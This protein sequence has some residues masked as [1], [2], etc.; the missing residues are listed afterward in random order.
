LTSSTNIKIIKLLIINCNG[1][2][3]HKKINMH[4]SGFAELH[5][6]N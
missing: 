5:L 4:A 2:W 3:E 1:A 6:H